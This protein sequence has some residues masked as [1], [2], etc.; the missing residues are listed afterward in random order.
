MIIFKM[1]NIKIVNNLH[2]L[3]NKNG[4]SL[5]QQNRSV[6][7][8]RFVSSSSAVHQFESTAIPMQR[9]VSVL[10]PCSKEAVRGQRR[11]A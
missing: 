7:L 4:V 2:V 11:E 6:E 5:I 3:I 10:P 1:N 9:Q 8:P